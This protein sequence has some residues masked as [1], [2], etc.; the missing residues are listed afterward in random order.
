VALLSLPSIDEIKKL[1]KKLG[2]TQAELAQLSQVSQ[3][4]VSQIESGEV[5][6]RL[7][8]LRRIVDALNGEEA[9]REVYAEDLFVKDL[10]SVSPDDLVTTAAN[11]MWTK[12]I[13]QLPVLE[14]GKNLGSISEKSITAE[15]AKGSAKD[16]ASRTVREAMSEPF[17]MVGRRSRMEVILSLLQDSSAV[18]V[19][20]DGKVSGIITK[21]DVLPRLRT[22]LLQGGGPQTPSASNNSR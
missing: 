12:K 14:N 8:T 18:L 19:L 3:S 22:G 7:S 11:I 16:L 20:D 1:R 9:G 15:I 2:L 13:S 5:D 10:V 6:P 4:L 21:A 17:P